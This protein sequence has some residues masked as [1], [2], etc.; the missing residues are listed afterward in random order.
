MNWSSLQMTRLS[1]ELPGKVPESPK[2]QGSVLLLK[3]FFFSLSSSEY[4]KQL[5]EMKVDLFIT[6]I[7]YK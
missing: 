7:N 2:R 4:S 6:Q 5:V 3:F 1:V